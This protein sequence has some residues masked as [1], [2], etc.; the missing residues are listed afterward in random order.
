MEHKIMYVYHFSGLSR[1]LHSNNL[2]HF[3][4]MFGLANL[5]NNS[6]LVAYGL[7]VESVIKNLMLNEQIYQK[8]CISANSFKKSVFRFEE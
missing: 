2:Y 6:Y 7:S 1:E 8:I 3:G 5:S 4:G